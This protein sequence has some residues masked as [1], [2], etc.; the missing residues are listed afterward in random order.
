MTPKV[1]RCVFAYIFSSPDLA[2][3]HALTFDSRPL[4]CC[5]LCCLEPYIRYSAQASP[6][7]HTCSFLFFCLFFIV[8]LILCT[9]LVC[10]RISFRLRIFESIVQRYGVHTLSRHIRCTVYAYLE[11]YTARQGITFS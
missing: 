2:L 4:T 10:P 8:F 1:S 9:H 11:H 7:R 3:S 5:C 6:T